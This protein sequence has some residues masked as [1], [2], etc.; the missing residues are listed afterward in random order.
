VRVAVIDTWPTDDLITRS[1][2]AIN[3]NGRVV[4][5]RLRDLK[6]GDI[7][8]AADVDTSFAVPPDI[9]ACYRRD[10]K[11][12][13]P[14]NV[15]DH[16]VFVAELIDNII[17]RITGVTLTLSVYRAMSDYG[18]GTQQELVKAVNAALH[19]PG[20]GPLVINLSLGVGAPVEIL[21][22]LLERF[23]ETFDRD[24]W[25]AIVAGFMGTRSQVELERLRN[26]PTMA[27]ARYLFYGSHN[28]PDDADEPDVLFVA[29]AGNDRVTAA[30]QPPPRFP[31]LVEKVIGVSAAAGKDGAG[32]PIYADF[33]NA[34][35]VLAPD[36]GL[37]G[38]GVDVVGLYLREY[39]GDGPAVNTTGWARWSGTSFA[40]PIISGVAA[41]LMARGVK[42]RGGGGGNKSGIIDCLVKEAKGNG[43]PSR[44]MMDL[45][46]K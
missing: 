36:D 2:A 4:N 34:D 15:V 14:Y 28:V 39:V 38:F 26:H 10:D 11:Y 12:D 23:D 21:P 33:S 44:P 8:K 9:H 31:A 17:R 41:V 7:V 24:K 46:Q 37:P 45:E 29:S 22:V 20:E 18:V 19:A 43:S 32:D 13:M 3:R 25:A 40:A 27:V 1:D 16:G 35:D 42:K 6:N 30:L 5:Q